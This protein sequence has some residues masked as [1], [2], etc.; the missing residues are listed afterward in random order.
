MA[1]YLQ[2]IMGAFSGKIGPVIGTSRNGVPYMKGKGKP[3]SGPVGEQEAENRN[4]FATGHAWL[5][6]LLNFLR[7]GFQGYSQ[8][9]YG[10]NA[11]KSYNFRYAMENGQMIPSKVNVSSGSLPLPADLQVSLDENKTLHFT[12]SGDYVEDTN[13]KD[14][15]MLL[16]YH[17]ESRTAIF[18]NYGAFRKSGL[19]RLEL[20]HAFAGKAIHVYAA[21]VAADRSRQSDSVYLGE[22]VA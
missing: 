18:E 15:L 17:P 7:V 13:E 9:T 8:T 21:F 3:R 2:G 22:I 16:A 12:W 5:K 1:K 4:R 10:Y 14:Q 20:F 6:P 19:E 11:A